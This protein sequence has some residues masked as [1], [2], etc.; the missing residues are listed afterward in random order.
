MMVSWR[1][2]QRYV[3]WLSDVTGEPYRLPTEAEW[4]FAARGGADTQYW[5]GDRFEADRVSRQSTVETGS[6]EA[7]PFGL[8]EMTG[9]VSE[10]VEDCYVNNYLEAPDDGRAIARGDCARRVL[11]G[12]S[13][14]DY[15]P[16]LRV[17]SRSRVGQTV[18]DAGIGFRVA[19][20]D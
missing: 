9:N 11:R 3:R 14:R 13:W 6:T 7:N 18:R 1:D 17:A 15:A 12:G 10:W 16:A 20:S 8:Y 5:W 19:R 4:E 2:A